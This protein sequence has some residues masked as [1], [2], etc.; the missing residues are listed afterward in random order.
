MLPHFFRNYWGFWILG[1]INNLFY[2][3]VNSAAQSICEDFHEE[4]LIGIIL[5]CN[6]GSGF[7]VRGLNVLLEKVSFRIRILA[8]GLV[9]LLGMIALAISKWV[10]FWFALTAIVFVGGTSNFGESAL[11]GF[12]R[13][14]DPETVGGWSSG[15]GA[16]GVLGAAIY[17]VLHGVGMSNLAIFLVTAPLSVVYAGTFLW[18]IVLPPP[19]SV[20]SPAT[21]DDKEKDKEAE[22]MHHEGTQLLRRDAEHGDIN[23]VAPPAAVHGRWYRTYCLTANLATQL[24]LVYFFEYVASVGCAD[25]AVPAAEREKSPRWEVRNSYTILSF[26]YQVGVL[27]SRSSLKLFKIH[28]VEILSILQCVN[29]VFWMCEA[30]WHFCDVWVLFFLMIYVGLLGGGAYV[31]IFY[32]VLHDGQVPPA[33]TELGM[34]LITLHIT[35][36]I[37]LAAAFVLIMENTFLPA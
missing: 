14:F 26:C 16:A 28:R 6:V 10:G 17:M 11:L 37:T 32:R 24:L 12:M 5:W 2:V 29:F 22:A 19:A 3:I 15:T 7:L 36:G 30:A 27:A 18:M 31:N 34:N 25:R 21:V 35:A 20:R 4:S 33:L 13:F 8:N 23:E 1:T 9:M